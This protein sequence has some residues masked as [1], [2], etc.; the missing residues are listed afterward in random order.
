[1]PVSPMHLILL[2]DF[3]STLMDAYADCEGDEDALQELR[4]EQ[5]NKRAFMLF[6]ASI[7]EQDGLENSPVNW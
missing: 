1:M 5:I 7:D 4:E 3:L 2:L 6:L